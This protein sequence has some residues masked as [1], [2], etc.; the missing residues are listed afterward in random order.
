MIKIG[1]VF[2]QL[3]SRCDLLPFIIV[4]KRRVKPGCNL[5]AFARNRENKMA[6]H[7]LSAVQQYD[8]LLKEERRTRTRATLGSLSV[9]SG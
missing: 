9:D 8:T 5:M 2:W 3:V 7:G 6:T 4:I 1:V